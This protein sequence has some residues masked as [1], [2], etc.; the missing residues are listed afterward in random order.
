MAVKDAK[1]GAVKTQIFLMSTG[2]ASLCR[3]M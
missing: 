2:I 1:M 3:A